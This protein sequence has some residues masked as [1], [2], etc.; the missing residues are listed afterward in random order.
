MFPCTYSLH[1]HLWSSRVAID[2]VLSGGL[3]MHWCNRHHHRHTATPCL[4][5]WVCKESGIVWHKRSE[6]NRKPSSL[7]PLSIPS[8]LVVALRVSSCVALS[9]SSPHFRRRHRALHIRC[10]AVDVGRPLTQFP[11]IHTDKRITP[12]TISIGT[13]RAKMEILF[14]SFHLKELFWENFQ[15]KL[16][17]YLFSRILSSFLLLGY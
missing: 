15:Q 9:S 17:P 5:L 14:L 8:S 4:S 1:T 7:H 16:V 12:E 6:E 10:R 13:R 11:F 3:P 2:D